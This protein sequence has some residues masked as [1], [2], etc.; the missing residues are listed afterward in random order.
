MNNTNTTKTDISKYLLEEKFLWGGVPK[1]V[2]L[3]KI[4][5]IRKMKR[6]S[7]MPIVVSEL[8]DES[9]NQTIDQLNGKLA[10]IRNRGTTIVSKTPNGAITEKD[11]LLT[12]GPTIECA[13]N[14]MA[15]IVNRVNGTH[16]RNVVLIHCKEN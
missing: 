1:F 4:S 12:V 5:D 11:E 6:M 7:V 13:I 15:D 8:D 9:A 2:A 14:V 16:C 3:K 10:A